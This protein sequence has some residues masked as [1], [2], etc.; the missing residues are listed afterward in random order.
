ML[1]PLSFDEQN[2]RSPTHRKKKRDREGRGSK[3]WGETEKRA[4]RA[5]RLMSVCVSGVGVQTVRPITPKLGSSLDGH[6]GR[7]I[8]EF[9]SCSLSQPP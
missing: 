9:R 3:G 1:A 4:T 8:G 7:D 6:L 5:K 2:N